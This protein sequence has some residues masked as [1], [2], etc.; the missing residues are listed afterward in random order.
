MPKVVKI[1]YVNQL[2]AEAADELRSQRIEEEYQAAK[3]ERDAYELN[4]QY[5][6][7]MQADYDAGYLG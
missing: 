3:R 6:A 1:E 4:S 7:M 2:F 5:F